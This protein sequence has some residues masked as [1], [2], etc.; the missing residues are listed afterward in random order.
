MFFSIS[1]KS[2]EEHKRLRI[3]YYIELT[4]Y[5]LM[6]TLRI[7]IA[8]LLATTVAMAQTPI[9]ISVISPKK[10]E[11]LPDTF[12]NVLSL[13]QMTFNM[14]KGTTPIPLVK[15][16]QM[17]YEYAIKFKDI[18]FEVRYAVAPIGYT[19]AEAYTGG[20][21]VTPRTGDERLSKTSSMVIAINVGG[22]KPDPNMGSREFPPEAVKK[23]FGADWG[24]TT[25][26]DLQ[27]DSFGT[28]YKYCMMI[29]LHK[30]DVA[31]GY[32]F[33]LSD[34]K[35]HLM[36]YLNEYIAKTGAFYAMKFK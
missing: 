26:I 6:F 1:G 4:K 8:L 22:G 30:N 29:T 32:I 18:P 11:A 35:E 31:D 23:E 15:N 10:S 33:Y 5:E 25:M 9:D 20:K 28:E 13:G 21:G 7:T 24:S 3:V 2:D 12:Q 19:V 34:T 27:N 36:G 17:H 14:P 16:M